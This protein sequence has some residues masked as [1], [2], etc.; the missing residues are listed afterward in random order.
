MVAPNSIEWYR[1]SYITGNMNTTTPRQVF[2]NAQ[3]VQNLGRAPPF[4]GQQR[5]TGPGQASGRPCPTFVPLSPDE[6]VIICRRHNPV[7]G[8][9]PGDLND[10]EQEV[11]G[12]FNT[13]PKTPKESTASRKR[14]QLSPS[15]STD[16][17]YRFEPPRTS[18][19]FPLLNR[20][21]SEPKKLRLH[22]PQHHIPLLTQLQ[23]LSHSQLV[24]TIEQLLEHHPDLEKE[25]SDILPNPDLH[26]LEEQLSQLKHNVYRSFPSVRFGSSRRDSYCYK[27]V[28]T[29]LVAF[30]KTC[31]EQGRVLL[32]AESW[33]AALE[34]VFMAWTYTG[35]LP[36]WED[37]AHN[38]CKLSCYRGLAVQC[39]YVLKNAVLEKE[40]YRDIREQIVWSN[41]MCGEIE[42]CI[43]KINAILDTLP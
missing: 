10:L 20:S 22:R 2:G 19:P 21:F 17:D 14:L 38:K 37:H 15:S 42:P 43:R 28:S 34:Y 29:H 16:G 40:Q 33:L 11:L 4:A 3:S 30:K 6:H 5:T 39:M 36:Q 32:K 1:M 23:G 31:L 9:E 25:L 35:Q 8:S 24:D 27:R 26:P 7:G 12:L 13:P 41:E 18:S